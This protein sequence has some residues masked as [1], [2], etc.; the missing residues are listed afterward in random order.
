M[1]QVRD[2]WWVIVDAGMNLSG[3]VQCETF[4]D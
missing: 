4:V 2:S 3:F 1:D